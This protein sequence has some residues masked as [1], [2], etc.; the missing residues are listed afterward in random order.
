MGVI[1]DLRRT[2]GSLRDKWQKGRR[3]NE[4]LRHETEHW[5]ERAER[6]ERERDHLR[7]EN[8]RLKRQLDDAQRPPNGRP[9]RLREASEKPIRSGRVGSPARPTE[10]VTTKPNPMTL[11]T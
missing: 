9:L 7:E 11:T 5:R 4:R 1:D 10:H 6:L 8:K 3:E 2:I